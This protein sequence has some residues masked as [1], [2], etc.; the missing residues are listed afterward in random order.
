MPTA[1][2]HGAHREPK[3]GAP[4]F[5]PWLY[6]R[7]RLADDVA[8]HEP[9]E[10]GQPWIL[11]RGTR[12]YFRVARDLARLVQAVDGLR[13]TDGLASALGKPWT[14]ADVDVA[15]R[16]LAKAKILDD[17]SRPRRPN[18]IVRFVP[19]LSL[20]LTL[21]RPERFLG[22]LLPVVAPLLTRAGV[23]GAALVA[24]AGVM[25][26][27][28]QGPAVHDALGRPLPLAVYVGLFGA[29]LAT[30]ALHELAHG[31][32]LAS[33]GGRPSRMGLML[34]YLAPAFF[35]DVS[36]GWRLPQNRS[37]VIVALAGIA[38]QVVVAGAAALA[39]PFTGPPPVRDALLIFAVA[40]YLSGVLNLI[41]F[42]KLD[43]YLAL[44]S[45]L[46][47]SH[48]RG[49]AIVDGR[50]FLARVLFGS[51]HDRELPTVR[52]A[53]WFGLACMSFP[54]YIVLG[55][56][57]LWVDLLQRLGTVGALMVLSGLGYLAFWVI[58]G[59]VRIVVLARAAGAPTARVAVVT[60]GL[61]GIV[62]A[63][64][65]FVP[66]PYT[67]SGGYVTAAD[68]AVAGR[69]ADIGR[70]GVDPR[71]IAGHALPVRSMTS[72]Q[73]GA[74]V[75]A[76]STATE[77]PAPISV[78]VPVQTDAIQIPMAAVPVDV[79]SMPADPTGTARVEVCTLPLW[80]W[81]ST[82]YIV[83]AWPF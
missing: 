17:G 56:L 23:I 35:C 71:R 49:R 7:P 72:E 41:P 36:D 40:T 76:S 43:G 12:S 14:A 42:V 61:L 63:A 66:L 39:A 79:S 48:L 45:H 1:T 57:S 10:A 6:V 21:L 9:V 32:V 22:R 80:E 29:I 77:T 82:K 38:T 81:L 55:A 4:T 26:L 27:I 15:V 37:R 60:G 75:L 18:S 62:V 31:V 47:I 33:F 5:K 44:M 50:R 8:V 70:S 65:A 34:F 24:V 3:S 64:L 58:R 73:V 13:D 69:A 30:T 59:F 25:A 67:L 11:Q 28:A 16:Q 52:W 74:G 53:V 20:Q 19:P 46:D 54:V 2:R 51:V 78:L 83:P 68:G